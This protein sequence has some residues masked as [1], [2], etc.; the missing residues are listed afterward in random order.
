M[1]RRVVVA[2]LLLVAAVLVLLEV[3]LALTFARREREAL[4]DDVGRDAASLAALTEEVLE[5]PAEHDVSALAG[6]FR[7]AGDGSTVAVVDADGRPIDPSVAPARLAGPLRAA[8]DRA[9]AGV[10]SAGRVGHRAYA[11]EPVGTGGEVHGAVLVVHTGAATERRIHQLWLALAVIALAAL[12]VAWVLGDRLA[13]WAIGPLRDLDERAAA[14]GRG[15]LGARADEGTGPREVVELART[16]NDMAGRLEELVGAQRRFIGDASHQLRSPLA[17]LRLRLDALDTDDPETA[18]ADVDAAVAE[19]V[20]LSR[21][22][23]GLLALARAEGSRPD[24]HPADVVEVVAARRAAWSAYADEHGV[25]LRAEVPD[26]PVMA[27]LVEGHLEQI[28][29]NLVDNAIEATPAGRAVTL[30]VRAGSPCVEVSVVDEGPGMSPQAMSRA[31][32]RFW[33]GDRGERSGSG[34][35][36][37]IAAQLARAGGGSLRLRTAPGG[38]VDALISLASA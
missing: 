27:S 18:Q 9:R 3:P 35:G 20:R 5:N 23:D 26:H 6:R 12:G 4:A 28:L 24:R 14:L 13:R 15:D 16:F 10:P 1:R 17:A 22:V 8:L 19:T 29:D 36:L 34:L 7:G 32:D 2:H 33:Q 21:L 25:D 37:P 30:A 31:F 38:G 11:A